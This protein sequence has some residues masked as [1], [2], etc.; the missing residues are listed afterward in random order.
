[1]SNHRI[2]T[3]LLFAAGVLSFAPL[4]HALPPVAKPAR[5]AAPAAARPT[6]AHPG[7]IEVK[8]TR[9]RLSDVYT[10]DPSLPDIDLGAA[11]PL[12]ATRTI[13]RAEIARALDA[14]NAPAPTTLPARVNVTRKAKKLSA[15][16]VD[17]IVRAAVDTTKLP[18]GASILSVKS[19]PTLD[20]PD[21]FEQTSAELVNVPRRAGTV[22]GSVTLVFKA[23]GDAILRVNVPI[24]VN[25]PPEALIPDVTKG[26]PI[27]LLVKKGLVEVSIGGV[28]ATDAEIGGTLPVLLKPSGRVVRARLL[29]KDHAIAIEGT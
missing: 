9:V 10:G 14:A 13:E 24:D 15:A 7:A 28:A 22:V 21:G 6:P 27:T 19:A 29:D 3:F 11:P 12:G 23:G 26:A 20:V 16:D 18:K 17:R 8:S 4:S 2:A 25:V 1:M 5:P